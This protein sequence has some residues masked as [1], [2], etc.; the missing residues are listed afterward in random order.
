MLNAAANLVFTYHDQ[1]LKPIPSPAPSDALYL[2]CYLAAIVGV[3]LLT[4][5]SFGRVHVSVRLDGAITGLAVASVAGILWFGALLQASGRPLTVVVNLAYPV[6]DLVL[7]VLLVAGLAPR[8]YR[9]TWPTALL[10][11][12]AASFAIASVFAMHQNVTNTFSGGRL[13]DGAWPAGLFLVGL[14]ASVRERRSSGGSRPSLSAPAGIAAVPALFGLVSVGVLVVSLF[15][16]P[17]HAAD[18]RSG[19]A[20]QSRPSTTPVG[21][22]LGTRGRPHD[23][24][25]PSV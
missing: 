21:R 13:S 16:G 14:A 18:R 23:C 10:M 3:A 22:V 9:P 12:G 4:Q 5:S 17:G 6:G 11:A 15:T 1:N 25:R 19:P 8:G 24:E 2:L 7:I 20:T